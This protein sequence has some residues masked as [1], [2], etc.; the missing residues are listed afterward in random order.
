MLVST[1]DRGFW[2]NLS[3]GTSEPT[4]PTEPNKWASIEKTGAAPSQLGRE[5]LLILDRSCPSRTYRQ[6]TT[7]Y[8]RYRQVPDQS[9][10]SSLSLWA[11]HTYPWLD[12][13]SAAGEEVLALSCAVT[14]EYW[15]FPSPSPP[16]KVQH[17]YAVTQQPLAGIYANE[18]PIL[19]GIVR[20]VINHHHAQYSTQHHLIQQ[21]VP[22]SEP[23]PC[24][25][26][27]A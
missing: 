25:G 1:A 10:C 9:K 23:C 22:S 16:K 13:Q 2:I 5:V 6:S 19:G 12:G 24:L 11:G 15:E 21:L 8:S 20:Y 18:H 27:V 14:V 4:E 17:R 7:T 26:P 3:D